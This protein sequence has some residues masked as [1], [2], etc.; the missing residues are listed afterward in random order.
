[1]G[2]NTI[3]E[4]QPFGGY[5]ISS[6]L[7]P[8]FTFNNRTGIIGGT[9]TAP[10]PATTFTV[11]GYN[12]S[13]SGSAEVTITVNPF[14]VTY[15][16]PPQPY[17]VGAAITPL[18]P[19]GSGGVGAPGFSSTPVKLGLGFSGATG[20]AVD[21]AGNIFVADAVANAV[22]EIPVGSFTPVVIASGLN[23]P[24]GIAVDASDN[25]YFADQ[26]NNEIKKIPFNSSTPV[27]IGSGFSLP[28]GVAVDAA[29]NVYVADYGN[30]EIKE[31]PVGSN[32]PAL[33]GSGFSSPV[34]VAVDGAGNVYVADNNNNVVN[35]ILKREAVLLLWPPA[36][37]IPTA[38]LSMFLATFTWRTI[39]T[40][41]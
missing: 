3:R 38:W 18:S 8:G 5:Y 29:G 12:S 30:N 21:G 25:I 24:F 34:G 16:T 27:V 6:F 2:D 41:K 37:A 17:T 40:M 39:S 28:T 33:I 20:V 31:I 7:P 11:T 1:M 32:T 9:P 14:I 19:G 4:I 36:S 10:I 15:S 13:G 35:E 23:G 26:N 22:K